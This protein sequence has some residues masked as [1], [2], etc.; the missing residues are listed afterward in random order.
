MALLFYNCFLLLYR[1]GV[2]LVSPWNDKA[3]L[4]LKGR[5]NWKSQFD[6]RLL[7]NGNRLIW[8]HCASLGEFEQGRPVLEKIKA[9]YPSYRILLTF[10]SPS[11]YE[12]RKNYNGAD[13][14]CYLP[15]DSLANARQFLDM[16]QP[17]L[18]LWVKYEYWYYYITGNKERRHI[19]LLL[20]SGI[21]REDQPFF[22]WYGGLHRKMLLSFTHLFVQTPDSKKRLEALRFSEN[23]TVSGGDTRFDRVI[24]IAEKL[25]G[26]SV[27]KRILW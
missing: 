13:I 27:D 1:A 20:V 10:F 8:M 19:P 12:V 16:V 17:A 22:K 21:F 23:V 18:V 26:C 24:E 11:G 25:G 9:Q 2:L 6:E 7:T 3:K 14:I 4:W 5:K 15:M